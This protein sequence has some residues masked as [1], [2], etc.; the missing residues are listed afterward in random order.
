VLRLGFLASNAGSSMRAI[1]GAIERGELDAEPRLVVSNKADA[2]ALA[3]AREHGVPS[4]CIPTLKHP[5]TADAKLAGALRE[6]GAELIVLSGYLRRLG[7]LTL[8]A[9]AGRVLN[10]HP[11]PLPQFGGEGMYGRRVHEAVLASGAG[12][13]G[14]CVHI[15]DEEYDHGPVLARL[16]TPLQAGDTA[17]DLERRVTAAE[18][19]FFVDTL[20]AV[21]DGRLALPNAT[22][23]LPS[24]LG[25]AKSAP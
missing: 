21:A 3:F 6:A 16:T 25:R 18:P 1:V 22:G 11:G 24:A 7:P 10:I 5:E 4:R 19:G 14:V 9:Y 17:E 2:G 12:Q 15:V 23:R 13:S 20:R 8:A